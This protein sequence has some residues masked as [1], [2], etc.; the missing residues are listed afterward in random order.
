MLDLSRPASH[1]RDHFRQDLSSFAEKR[2]LGACER[3]N[4]PDQRANPPPAAFK[5]QPLAGGRRREINAAAVLGVL[6]SDNK[7]LLFESANDPCH[8]WRT[9]LLGRGK[10]A[11]RN[12]ASKHDHRKSRE[13]RRIQG[14]ALV[15]PPQFAEQVDRCRVQPLGSLLRRYLRFS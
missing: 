1:V 10:V 11:Q 4:L 7:T 15:F 13:T 6:A 3:I 5:K 14:A 2:L 9:Y 12:G 8:G